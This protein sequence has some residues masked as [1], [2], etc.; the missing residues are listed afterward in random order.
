M[1]ILFIARGFPSQDDPMN[2]NYEAEQARAM[3]K[4]GHE[5]FYLA[6]PKW[7]SIIHVPKP[8]LISFEVD[9]V[10][11]FQATGCSLPYIPHFPHLNSVKEWAKSVYIERFYLKIV[12]AFGKP[13]LVHVHTLY[14]S[15]CCMSLKRK[16]RIPIVTTEHWSGINQDAK[17][18]CA[19]QKQGQKVYKQA[20]AVISV[21][22]ALANRIYN[23]W[24]VN[25][26]VIHNLVDSRF[27]TPIESLRRRE[28]FRFI[29]VGRLV[30][31]KRYDLLI[32]S[33]VNARLPESA[34]LFIVGSGEEMDSL[35][36]LIRN[37]NA[38]NRVYLL[39]LKNKDEV[40]KLLSES[41]CFVCTSISETFGIALIE[42]MSKGLPVISVPCG[43]PEE[44]VTQET[45]LLTKDDKQESIS[46][47]MEVMVKSYQKYNA[48]K[49][50]NY[51][52][53]QFSEDAIASQIDRI[54]NLVKLNKYE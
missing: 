5:V 32:R 21:S 27:W 54:Y 1:K 16:Y 9:G 42:A 29:A 48:D 22:Q 10:K 52:Y 17:P 28:G 36:G 44:F 13:D 12:A 26:Y 3:A 37:L 11:V 14:V 15:A 51:C 30:A 2:G 18:S 8:E 40:A 43:G 19:I 38:G 6:L 20:D 50:K 39:G 45:G 49:I 53:T 7:K 23:H 24:S 46:E 47:A 33:F 25:S 35:N 41:H 34:E 31:I 4:Y